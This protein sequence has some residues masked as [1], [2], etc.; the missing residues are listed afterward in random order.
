MSGSSLPVSLRECASVGKHV[1]QLAA[2]LVE[3]LG[4]CLAATQRSANTIRE[5][6]NRATL[7]H[8]ADH[9][10]QYNLITLRF[11]VAD[12]LA[13]S[14]SAAPNDEAY[15]AC[16]RDIL[17]MLECADDMLT[18]HCDPWVHVRRRK[19][20]K[21]SVLGVLDD[22]AYFLREAFMMAQ[23]LASG[24]LPEEAGAA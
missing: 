9:L 4:I 16:A 22:H 6:S 21:E 24:H 14:L 3:G 10:R 11:G 15:A 8:Y 13:R 19:R 23:A 12:D 17:K 1:A 20:F 5:A 2:E 7:W 18:G